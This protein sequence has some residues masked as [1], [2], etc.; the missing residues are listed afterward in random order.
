LQ[1]EGASFVSV[2]GVLMVVTPLFDCSELLDR[3]RWANAI[4]VPDPVRFA[5]VF[6]A[7]VS[8]VGAF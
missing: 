2:S 3:T 1:I 5:A 8:V 7:G 6:S 4:E